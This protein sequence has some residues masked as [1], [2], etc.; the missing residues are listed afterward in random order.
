MLGGISLFAA[1]VYGFAKF[2]SVPGV[3]IAVGNRRSYRHYF[4]S[5]V[6]ILPKD[7]GWPKDDA[8]NQ[9][10]SNAKAGG[11]EFQQLI[12]KEGETLSELRPAGFAAIEKR[13]MDVVTQGEMVLKGE[14]VRVIACR[15][16]SRRCCGS[17]EA[18]ID[19]Q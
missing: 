4:R 5:L 7:G 2:G 9:D 1:V 6:Q 16:K 19:R 8:S 15:R 14:R 11:S 3:L 12:G 18:A 17:Q 13:R 10:L